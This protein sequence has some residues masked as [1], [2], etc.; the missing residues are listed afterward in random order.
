M[1]VLFSFLACFIFIVLSYPFLKLYQLYGYKIFDFL[2][3]ASKMPVKI[4]DDKNTL[5][6]TKRMLRFLVIFFA[7]LFSIFVIIFLFI[8]SFWLVLLFLCLCVVLVPLLVAFAH[9]LIYPVER[10]IYRFYIE[11]TKKSLKNFKGKKVAIVGSFGKTSVKNILFQLLK[12]KFRCVCTPKNFNTPMGIAKTVKEMKDDTEIAIFEMGARRPGE[13]KELVSL[14]DPDAGILTSIGQQHLETFKSMQNIENTKNELVKFIKK[15]GILVFNGED[16]KVLKSFKKCTK[17][18]FLV[19]LNEGFAYYE[20]LTYSKDGLSFDLIIDGN[21]KT[22]KTRL[23]GRF[24]ATNIVLASAV[25]YILGLGFDEI[26]LRIEKLESAKNRLE[27]IENKNFTIID[28]SYN[29][30]PIGCEEALNVLEMFD[31]EKVVVTSGMVELGAVQYE[32]NFLLGKQIGKVADYVL[33]MNETNKTAILEGIKKS[34]FNEEK[35][36]FANSRETQKEVLK[37]IV[38]KGSVVLFQN[39]LP[40]SYR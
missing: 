1:F 19:G 21:Q 17:T 36:F 3:N 10:L 14:V 22:V 13:I 25:A 39:D 27:L 40:D 38:K 2:K 6:L 11:K 35:I 29:A 16:E 20:N 24:N 34:R 7:T 18:K 8:K 28:D 37:Q 9:M 26:C 30:N 33:I 32:K 15:E 12:E 4:L 23:L 31:G 5:V